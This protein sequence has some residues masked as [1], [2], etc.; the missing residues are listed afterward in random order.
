MIVII[1]VEECNSDNDRC[2]I[3]GRG[4]NSGNDDNNTDTYCSIKKCEVKRKDWNTIRNVSEEDTMHY[5]EGG[6]VQR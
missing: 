6:K 1:M 4:N 5:R 3:S 2:D